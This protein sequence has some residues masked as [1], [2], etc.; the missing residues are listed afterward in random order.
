[1]DQGAG[2]VQNSVARADGLLGSDSD[3]ALNCAVEK[4]PCP[5]QQSSARDRDYVRGTSSSGTDP[6]LDVNVGGSS[7]SESNKNDSPAAEQPLSRNDIDSQTADEAILNEDGPGQFEA[8]SDPCKPGAS[9]RKPSKKRNGSGTSS[10]RKKAKLGLSEQL[11]ELMG[12]KISAHEIYSHFAGS[13]KGADSPEMLTHLFYS[14]ACQDAFVQLKKAIP[15]LRGSMKISFS[16]KTVLDNLKSLDQVAS[17]L[18]AGRIMQRHLLV[19]LV[20]HR[21][22]L[23]EK[24]KPET[25]RRAKMIRE[26]KRRL[27]RSD[28]LALDEMIREAYPTAIK[29]SDEYNKIR[30][31]LRNIMSSGRNLHAL[32][33]EFGK[34][35]L[36]LILVGEGAGKSGITDNL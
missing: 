21:N 12:C 25:Y 16:A 26:D 34:E 2:L 6:S 30:T 19:E 18:T 33:D 3:D 17:S 36:D 1:M 28:G 20:D 11:P 5:S 27:E 14:I 8:P 24:Y 9:K 29:G 32:A 23:V 4:E 15:Q 13:C 7:C 31:T 22:Q 35:I 10:Q